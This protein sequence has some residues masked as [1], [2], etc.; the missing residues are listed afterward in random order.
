[1]RDQSGTLVE[2]RGL[3]SLGTSLA[4]ECLPLVPEG[5]MSEAAF[6]GIV[7]CMNSSLARHGDAMGLPNVL[8]AGAFGL[9]TGVRGLFAVVGARGSV[10]ERLV[11][12][13]EVTGSNPVVPNVYSRA[14][15]RFRVVVPPN[16]DPFHKC[17]SGRGFCMIH[18]KIALHP[19]VSETQSVW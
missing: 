1:M 4:K 10:V 11:H 19:P 6:C 16:P 5:A 2:E 13:E 9:K 7:R 8:K 17:G 15:R 14:D 12:T 18:R 3:C